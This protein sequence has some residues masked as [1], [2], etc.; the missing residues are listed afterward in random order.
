M[1][2]KLNTVAKASIGAG[3]IEVV[4]VGM[5]NMQDVQQAGGLLIQIVIGIITIIK[6]L[7]RKKDATNE[8][9]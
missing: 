2:E 5:T 4:N 1:I 8:K 6:M 9:L 3:A 7:K